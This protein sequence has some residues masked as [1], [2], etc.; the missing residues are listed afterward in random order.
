[1]HP[2]F[3]GRQGGRLGRR[4]GGV[5]FRE[6]ACRGEEGGDALAGGHFAG[7]MLAVDFGGAAAQPEAVFEGFELV[8]EVSHV[9]DAG[10]AGRGGCGFGDWG[11]VIVIVAGMGPGGR[12]AGLRGQ[13][14]NSDGLPH[15]A[16][17]RARNP[18]AAAAKAHL[19]A[20]SAI[21][22]SVGR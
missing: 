18:S 3:K 12:E 10:D 5:R 19:S 7:A 6:R 9:G 15:I 21:I 2:E 22:L 14:T 4:R 16:S 8:D 20:S 11:H 1:V 13:T 17:Q